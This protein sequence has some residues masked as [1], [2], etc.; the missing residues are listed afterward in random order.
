MEKHHLKTKR[1]DKKNTELV[2][3]ECHKTIHSLFS[4]TELRNPMLGLD[5]SEGLLA[6]ERMQKAIKFIKK[7]PPGEFMRTKESNHRKN[8]TYEK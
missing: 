1:V 5:T 3:R 8:L 7:L 6:N 4:N 2:C